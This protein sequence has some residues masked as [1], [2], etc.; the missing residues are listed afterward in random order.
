MFVNQDVFGFDVSV[1]N[2]FSMQDIHSL[3]ELVGDSL[4]LAPLKWF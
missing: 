3:E 4:N 1:Q 2:H